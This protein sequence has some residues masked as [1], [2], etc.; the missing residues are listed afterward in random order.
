[1]FY[2]GKWRFLQ[3]MLQ[4]L[5]W[6]YLNGYIFWVKKIY[7]LAWNYVV[8]KYVIIYRAATEIVHQQV[9]AQIA[10]LRDLSKQQRIL[11]FW[12]N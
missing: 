5:L 10:V 7:V 8:G 1:M 12:D 2:W 4:V 11:S 3:E 6:F 9:K